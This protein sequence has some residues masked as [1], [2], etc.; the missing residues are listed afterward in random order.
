MYGINTLRRMIVKEAFI[1]V[2]AATALIL[3]I[4]FFYINPNHKDRLAGLDFGEKNH[5]D[6]GNSL[7]Q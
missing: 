3:P 6:L 4:K 5:Q 7:M 1:S 2:A